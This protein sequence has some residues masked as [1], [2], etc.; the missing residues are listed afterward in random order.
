MGEYQN[1]KKDYLKFAVI[2]IK[3]AALIKMARTARILKEM[4]AFL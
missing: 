3:D 2:P 1:Y 4:M